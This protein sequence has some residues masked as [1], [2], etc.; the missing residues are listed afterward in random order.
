MHHSA[1]SSTRVGDSTVI[2]FQPSIIG[3]DTMVSDYGVARVIGHEGW[4]YPAV[5]LESAQALA[6]SMI[7]DEME[8][9]S[10][11]RSYKHNEG[12]GFTSAI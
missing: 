10:A 6:T 11:G 5:N 4:A 9:Y 8:G 3:F 2:V 12:V 7:G 1:V